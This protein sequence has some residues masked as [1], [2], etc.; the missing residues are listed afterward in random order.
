MELCGATRADAAY[1]LEVRWFG[2]RDRGYRAEA[3]QQL[4]PELRADPGNGGQESERTSDRP[5]S[6][7]SASRMPTVAA[8]SR[9]H[10]QPDSS[11]LR[12]R[13]AKNR[14]AAVYDLQNRAADTERRDRPCV[15]VW[16]FD[17]EIHAIEPREVRELSPEPSV[18]DRP[19]QV[20][21]GLPL[22]HGAR[23]ENVVTSGQ[24]DELDLDSERS[25]MV[26][27]G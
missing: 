6:S 18:H 27:N 3:R 17:D 9:E 26:W 19:M 24:R 5:A 12:A 11:V 25:E 22:D 14:H 2:R 1:L 13:A 20:C 10:A 7:T 16:P 23:T 15:D 8:P 4:L 21:N